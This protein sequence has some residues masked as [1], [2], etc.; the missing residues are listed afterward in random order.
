M[1]AVCAEILHSNFFQT[2]THY[3]DT[4]LTVVQLKEVS[5]FIKIH[6]IIDKVEILCF[7]EVFLPCHFFIKIFKNRIDKEHTTMKFRLQML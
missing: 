7:R 3:H 6:T 4:C 5:H 1:Y 2:Y